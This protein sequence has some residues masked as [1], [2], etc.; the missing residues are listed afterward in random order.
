[1][2][3]A[4]DCQLGD[5]VVM[6]T[7]VSGWVWLEVVFGTE[8]GLGSS[9]RPQRGEYWHNAQSC[10]SLRIF[11][12]LLYCWFLNVCNLL[13]SSFNELLLWKHFCHED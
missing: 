11:T 8:C 7:V 4:L 1:M 10:L 12:N 13:L 9:G 5:Y 6:D 3:C 2:F